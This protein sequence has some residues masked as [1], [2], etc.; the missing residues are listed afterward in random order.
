M[1]DH[2]LRDL[3]PIPDSGWSAIESEAK[4]RLTTYLAARKLVEFEGPEGWSRS[5]VDLGRVQDVSS[6]HE[7]VTAS[8][9]NVATLV[10]LRAEFSVARKE[11]E[12]ADRGATDI[13]L[14]DLDKAAERIALAE[15]RAVF[16]GYEAGGIEGITQRSSHEPV[17]LERD[18]HHYPNS[19]AKAVDML[20]QCGVGGPYGLAVSPDDYTRI[21]ETTELGGYPLLDH[22]RQILGGPVVWTPGITGGVVLSMRGEGDFVFHCG[23]DVSIGY[24]NHDEHSVRLYFEES[25]TF[26][27]GEPDAAVALAR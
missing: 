16:D 3:A 6:P 21:I 19:M 24:L 9:R 11:L 17:A 18:I 27:V 10:E 5:A 15:T 22:L 20:R 13:E 14:D 26:R 8:K 12:D 7:G 4:Q 23:Q 25:F 2:L 1:T